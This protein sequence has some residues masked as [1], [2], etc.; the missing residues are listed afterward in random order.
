MENLVKKK[1][2]VYIIEL[3]AALN[4]GLVLLFNDLGLNVLFYGM[5]LAMYNTTLIFLFWLVKWVFDLGP[6]YVI[7]KQALELAKNRKSVK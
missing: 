6:E 7:I 3:L 1:I 2:G 5:I 4:A